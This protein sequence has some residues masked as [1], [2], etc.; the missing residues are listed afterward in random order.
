MAPVD[1][2]S[3]KNIVVSGGARGIGRA[4]SRIFLETGHR[5]FIFDV[6][7]DELK[8]TT[9]AH[10]A[11][12][13]KEGKVGSAICNLRDAK[14]IRSKVVEAGKFFDGRIDVLINNGSIASPYWKDEKTMEDPDTLDEWQAYIDTNLTSAFA[15][16]QA[17]IP[18][19]KARIADSEN[20][21][22][23]LL[24]SPSER[25]KPGGICCKQGGSTRVDTINGYQPGEP[26][27]TSESDRTWT[28]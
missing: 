17:C 27:N 13:H 3:S 26:R 9:T 5:V 1:P 7:E 19:M 10:L 21:K 25:P 22:H 8:H 16:S 12:Y 28:D 20:H 18:Y 23:W 6:D 15:M 2:S 24:P 14:S 11:K 4:L